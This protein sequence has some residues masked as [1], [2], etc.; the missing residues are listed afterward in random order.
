MSEP[1][2]DRPEM[3]DYGLSSASE[4]ELRPWSWAVERLVA[5]RNYFVSTVRPDGRPHAMPVW[6]VWFDDVLWFNTS[7]S[8][9]KTRNLA[10]NS[11]CVITTEGADECVILEGTAARVRDAAELARF[12]G[13]YKDK[14]DWNLAESTD[15][16]FEVRPRVVFGFVEAADQF[17]KTAT[18]WR[19]E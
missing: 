10:E 17:A 19:F 7:P 16:T 8:S 18:R 11:G 2:A 15:A 12:V 3:P 13:L 5:S 9:R 14:Y 6:G 4:G 1:R